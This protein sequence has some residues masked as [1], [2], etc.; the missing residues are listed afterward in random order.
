MSNM[1]NMPLQM[2][3]LNNSF[4]QWVV[5]RIGGRRPNAFTLFLEWLEKRVE[6]RMSTGL[7]EKRR[8]MLQSLIEAKDLDGQPVKKG[9]VMIEGVNILAAGADTITVGILAII[10]A[11]IQ[12]PE[13]H[14]LVKNEIDQAYET[15]GLNDRDGITYKEA[16]KLPLLSAVIQE[17]TRLHPSM[18]YQLPRRVPE[19]GVQIGSFHAEEGTVCSIN[20]ASMN[21]SKEIFGDDAD[22]WKPE[23]WI[24]N[25]EDDAD[26]I[27][28]QAR[29]LTTV[30]AYHVPALGACC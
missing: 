17:S 18:Q 11:L 30:Y 5:K 29:L 8:D 23:R 20:A 26:R 12:H 25:S 6:D 2:L 14:N 13:H 10:G 24:A 3:W 16:Q 27:K 15:L 21:R 22:E 4:A 1:G 9:D 28:E 7:G 19:G